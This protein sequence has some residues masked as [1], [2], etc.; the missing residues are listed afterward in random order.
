MG[1]L[2]FE[3]LSVKAIC[4][5]NRPIVTSPK[6]GAKRLKR[7]VDW[8]VNGSLTGP[9]FSR[10]LNQL[11]QLEIFPARDKDWPVNIINRHFVSGP[12]SLSSLTCLPLR[13]KI[14]SQ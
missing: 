14:R 11:T 8:L 9:I 10:A 5:V 7:Q 13:R 6:R 4:S 3:V 2:P 12:I 1:S